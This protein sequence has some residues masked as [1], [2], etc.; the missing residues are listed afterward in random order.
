MSINSISTNKNSLRM[1]EFQR[2]FELINND[3]LLTHPVVYEKTLDN[4]IAIS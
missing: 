4:L 3:V 1:D 2:L